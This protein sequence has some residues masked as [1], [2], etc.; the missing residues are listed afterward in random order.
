MTIVA[1]II[2]NPASGRDIRRLVAHASV[3]GN[4][5]K[6]NIVRRVLLG[7]AATGVD[8]VLYMPDGQR[9]VERAVE[10]IDSHMEVIRVGGI[11]NG[12]ALDTAIAAAS[13]QAAGARVI[14]SLGGDGTNRMVAKGALDVPLVPIS[15]GTNNVFPVMVEGTVAGIAAGALAARAADP[16]EVA[17]RCKMVEIELQNDKREL[18]LIDAVVMGPGFIGS[19]AIWETD[20]VR[21]IL[22]ARAQ[23]DSVG[24]SALG[25]MV[26]PV[27]QEEDCGLHL[28]V[29]K[30]GREE[31]STIE[32]EAAIAPGL[33]EAVTLERF[34]RIPLGC[35]VQVSG[36]ALLALDGEREIVL[37][38]DHIA[39]LSVLRTGPR[40]VDIAHC[41]DAARASGFFRRESAVEPVR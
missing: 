39:R 33:I 28:V 17:P 29:G 2:A 20:S 3:F 19:R 27:S 25:G 1:G 7:M 41:L 5:E 35:V 38:K 8:R 4:D 23:S 30:T 11:F 24:M 31:H 15:T 6:I 13:M 36:P 16:A 9:L 21:E 37:P 22:L 40:V 14:V 34:E 32:V 26:M 18:A 12:K 10:E